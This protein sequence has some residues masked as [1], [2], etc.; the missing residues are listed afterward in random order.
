MSFG[1]HGERP[2][3]EGRVLKQEEMGA[4]QHLIPFLCVARTFCNFLLIIII[5]FEG[6]IT[7]FEL[8]EFIVHSS[9][10]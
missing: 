5:F 1:F 2:N 9:V 7:H 4:N 3:N 10:P 8:V 6:R